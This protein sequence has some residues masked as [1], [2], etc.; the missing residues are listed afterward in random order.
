MNLSPIS[1]FRPVAFVFTNQPPLWTTLFCNPTPPQ[2]TRSKLPR[3]SPPTSRPAFATSTSSHRQQRLWPP[4]SGALP[5]SSP[6]L[7]LTQQAAT[8]LFAN[9]TASLCSSHHRCTN[10]LLLPARSPS[11]PAVFPL[12]K[13]L[14]YTTLRPHDPRPS[15]PSRRRPA[16]QPPPPHESFSHI[17]VPSSSLR[18]HQP[19][20]TLDHSLLQPNTAPGH[21]QQAATLLSANL[22]ARLCYQ[23]QQPPPAAPVA[24]SERSTPILITASIPDAASRHAALRQPHGQPLLQPSPLHK[25]TPAPGKIPQFSG[26]IPP[27]QV[28]P[29]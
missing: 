7:F 29:L 26:G 19:A 8:P 5:S 27:L 24:S 21:P 15:S 14:H 3:R 18:L 16:A 2:V 9:L 28:P 13:Y 12:C 20:A 4:P 22:T 1:Q 6:P 17:S 10:P 25:P 11:S 23:H